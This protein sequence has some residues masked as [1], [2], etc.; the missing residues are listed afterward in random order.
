[1][2]CSHSS[3]ASESDRILARVDSMSTA[4]VRENWEGQIVDAKFPLLQRLG[5]SERS[6]VFRT[7][8]AGP[9]SQKAV[10]KLIPAV[11]RDSDRQLVRWASAAKLSHPHLLRV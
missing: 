2:I 5:G 3:A 7:E 8:F 11:S 4:V 10:I 1:M 9:R 6:T